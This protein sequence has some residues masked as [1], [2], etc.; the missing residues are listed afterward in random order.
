MMALCFKAMQIFVYAQDDNRPVAHDT[1]GSYRFHGFVDID[2]EARKDNSLVAHDALVF[3]AVIVNRTWKFPAAMKWFPC[4]WNGRPIQSVLLIEQCSVRLYDGGVYWISITCDGT[5]YHIAMLKAFC[6][7]IA[8]PSLQISCPHPS[9]SDEG[10]R[11]FSMSTP[12]PQG[13]IPICLTCAN[14][15]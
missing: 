12:P 6:T 10:M 4:Q 5:S 9:N 14:F 8:I 11:F 2:V 3:M 13:G 1:L 15:H 7:K